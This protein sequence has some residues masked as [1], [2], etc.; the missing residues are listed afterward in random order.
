MKRSGP[1]LSLLSF[2]KGICFRPDGSLTHRDR[3]AIAVAQAEDSE[4]FELALHHEDEAVV[5]GGI[6]GGDEKARLHDQVG[7]IV[8]K[9]FDDV[10]ALE[11][12]TRPEQLER[13]S[14][15]EEQILVRLVFF[16]LLN[17][18]HALGLYEGDLFEYDFAYTSLAVASPAP[19]VSLACRDAL[20]KISVLSLFASARMRSDASTPSARSF[21]ACALNVARIRSNTES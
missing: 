18:I 16:E 21:A 1:R 5:A 7:A 13:R 20:A 4:V 8:D 9:A 19:R 14:G 3:L 2:P 17:E 12:E 6:G 11:G 10:A 15:V